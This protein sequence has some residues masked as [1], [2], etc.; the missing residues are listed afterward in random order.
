MKKSMMYLGTLMVLA[1]VAPAMA[2]EDH[3]GSMLPG[4]M[5]L[6]YLGAAL[7]AGLVVMGG[8][9]GIGNIGASAVESTARQPEAGGAI[10]TAMILSAALIEG[11]T[12]FGLVITLLVVLK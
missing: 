1:M 2:A 9:R 8:A 3:G 11:A 7:G 5:G 12:L 10:F 6:A 4:G